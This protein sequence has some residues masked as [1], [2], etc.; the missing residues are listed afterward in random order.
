[1]TTAVLVIDIQQALCR[2]EWAAFEVDR[3][4]A[5]INQVTER[6]RQASA[7]VLLIQH[8]DD[9]PLRFSTEGWQLD[10]R[11]AVAPADIRIRKTAT[12]SFHR[13]ELQT[14]L[15]ARGIERLV[16]CGLQ[17]EFCIDSTV[18]GALALGYPVTLVADAH[19]TTDNG[20]L[21][22]AQITAHHNATL[23]NLESFGPR[24]APT[25]AAQVRFD[26]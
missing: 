17:S 25:L 4:I 7:P 23:K 24:V 20:V 14:Q 2:G 9:G 21:T 6:A 3:V 10:P 26:V 1:M 22:A 11:L 16:I 18:R 5:R 12:D 15:Q 19:S 8:E 13:T